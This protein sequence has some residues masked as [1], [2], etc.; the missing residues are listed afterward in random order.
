MKILN[1]QITYLEDRLT[2]IMYKT[3]L[4]GLIKFKTTYV[5]ENPYSS[6]NVYLKVDE[7]LTI[8][9]VVLDNN[10]NHW[11]AISRNKLQNCKMQ[12]NGI[13]KT[14]ISLI[15]VGMTFREGA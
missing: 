13:Y 5:L 11:M 6:G 3:Y 8:G 14:P 1:E 15:I 9:S 10:G 4:F 2:E 7:D 12:F